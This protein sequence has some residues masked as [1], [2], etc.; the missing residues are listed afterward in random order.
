MSGVVESETAP[1]V[2]FVVGVT[3][4]V[5]EREH[6]RVETVVVTGGTV[7]DVPGGRGAVAIRSEK[8]AT[9]Q[10]RSRNHEAER[11]KTHLFSSLGSVTLLAMGAIRS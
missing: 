5:G 10:V 2:S 6:E 7:E 9:S 11:G 1:T 4:V 8:G 3:R